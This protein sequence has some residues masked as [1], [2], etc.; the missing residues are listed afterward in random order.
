MKFL[1]RFKR[2]GPTEPPLPEPKKAPEPKKDA[3]SGYRPEIKGAAKAPQPP[4]STVQL[5]MSGVKKASDNELRL[6]LGDF[7]HRIPAHLLLTGP[8]DLKAELR[9]DI[10]DLSER[11]AKGQTTISLAEIYRRAPSIFRGE[12]LES[13]NIEV[14][15]PWQKLA[16][17][18]NIPKPASPMEATAPSPALADKLRAKKPGRAIK[19]AEAA[20]DM[21]AASSPVLPGRGGASKG[22]TWF[23]KTDAELPLG[24]QTPPVTQ[25]GQVSD[26]DMSSVRAPVLRVQPPTPAPQ[27]TIQPPSPAA[28]ESVPQAEEDL[29]IR[30]LAPDIQRRVAVL[31]GEYERQITEL[32][33]QRSAISDARDRANDEVAGLRKECDERAN[34]LAQEQSA[35]SMTRDLV[36][37]HQKEREDYQV[38]I[39]ELTAQLAGSGIPAIAPPDS[40]EQVAALTQERDALQKQKAYLSAQLAEMTNRRSGPTTPA[41]VNANANANGHRQVEELQRR[42][43]MLESAQK[44]AAQVLQREKESKGKVEKLLA[45]ADRLQRDSALHMEEAKGEMRKDIEANFRKQI[46]E[47]E[48]K[49]HAKPQAAPAVAVD[50]GGAAAWQSEMVAQLEAD[51]ENYRDRLKV[52][53][54]ERDEARRGSV[55]AGPVALDALQDELGKARAGAE[56][57]ASELR[58]VRNENAALLGVHSELENSRHRISQLQNELSDKLGTAREDVEAL[59]TQLE[60]KNSRLG[61]LETANS[62]ASD[63][64][65]ATIA[66]AHEQVENIKRQLEQQSRDHAV[67]AHKLNIQIAELKAAFATQQ[68]GV[69]VEDFANLRA[70]HAQASALLAE[71][72]Q[73]LE[74]ARQHVQKQAME[75]AALAAEKDAR[76][77]ELSQSQ[78][79]GASA[80]TELLKLRADFENEVSRHKGEH[81]QWEFDRATLLKDQHNL[82]ESLRNLQTQID[83]T[84]AERDDLA[85]DLRAE[86]QAHEKLLTVIDKDHTSVV[87]AKEQLVRQLAAA[88]EARRELEQL[89]GQ[90]ADI[91]IQ[92]ENARLC[93][94]LDGVRRVRDAA[95]QALE[96]RTSALHENERLLSRLTAENQQLTASMQ[97]FEHLRG[98]RIES[99]ET[100]RT[101]LATRLAEAEASLL[102]ISGER[103][104]LA[105]SLAAFE[106]QV[107]ATSSTLMHEQDR[108]QGQLTQV[109][110]ERDMLAADLSASRKQHQQLIASLDTERGE[111][112][113]T[114]EAAEKRLSVADREKAELAAS[115]RDTAMALTAEQQKVA[116]VEAELHHQFN[117]RAAENELRHSAELAKTQADLDAVRQLLSELRAASAQE[118][119]AYL[120]KQTALE[121]R[122][123]AE[124]QERT[125]LQ[126]SLQE[127]G[128][129]ERTIT[130]LR[131]E[132]EQAVTALAT[133]ERNH[134]NVLIETEQRYRDGLA[135]PA[136]ELEQF[137]ITSDTLRA[138][139]V[140]ARKMQAEIV[141]ALERD[142]EQHNTARAD[143]ERK[144]EAIDDARRQMSGRLDER[145]Q[146]IRLLE[147]KLTQ[148]NAGQERQ[149]D[150]LAELRNTLDAA[151]RECESTGT[152]GAA[153]ERQLRDEIAAL[154][155]KVEELV[156][157]KNRLSGHAGEQE[158]INREAQARTEAESHA[159]FEAVCAARDAVSR[160]LEAERARRQDDI[161]AALKEREE[162]LRN[163][164][165]ELGRIEQE[166]ARTRDQRELFKREKDDL[167]RRIA[168]ITEQQKRMLDDMAAGLGHAPVTPPRVMPMPAPTTVFEVKAEDTNVS[169]PRIRPVQIRPP[170]VKVL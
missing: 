41:N 86:S 44:E 35:N 147:E 84:V 129:H 87:Q 25:L 120:E 42:I 156:A 88:E 100:E 160:E 153:N 122:L 18:V 91:G 119:D 131:A 43:L 69:P 52:L 103:Q 5:T 62:T 19:T 54:R 29:S 151:R 32:T 40:D 93:A 99:L 22:A 1:D 53:I 49:L 31:K 48:D 21:N 61:N 109:T 157:D 81:T 114:R 79:G 45:N 166:L 8:H 56:Q 2:K 23:T 6:E 74:S 106:Q 107:S 50:E 11:I 169:L 123:T 161:A 3:N 17:L 125:T 145:E 115:L 38:Q 13:D 71:V 20:V 163:A 58:E 65:A 66:A 134:A 94:E 14:R 85:A 10:G 47:L 152:R 78:E 170:Q 117:A 72:H 36:L 101:Q 144:L 135:A 95:E 73:Q 140:V 141:G 148:A 55:A 16:K 154:T 128:D 26:A 24:L 124:V 75:F 143:W 105:S 59:K 37:R 146:T 46:K 137:R 89:R 113:T 60:E 130:S 34:Q 162:A 67:E 150:D 63:L 98:T 138:E 159:R 70:D 28:E 97:E 142:R 149:K 77:H 116:S 15:F 121:H 112:V 110:T 92:A 108:L 90:S 132:C 33:A 96:A 158:S 9:F 136:R 30:D 7:L 68:S 12:V 139:L 80:N 164:V 155:R 133:A 4:P 83:G 76:I 27:P 104:S 64:T 118:R 168:Q 126:T 57:M 165:G 111:L 102:Q 127:V 39:D 167:A 51:I 82:Q